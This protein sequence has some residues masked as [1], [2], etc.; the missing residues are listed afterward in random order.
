VKTGADDV[1]LLERECPG[2]RPAIRGRDIGA[3]ECHPRRYL[4]WTHGA[5]GLPLAQLTRP[6]RERLAC[7]EAR[8]RQR[9]DYRAGPPWQLFRTALGLAPHRVVWPDL[10]RRL[11]AVVPPADIV[12]LNTVYGIAT[13]DAADAG[14]LCVLLNSRWLTA[15]A[16]LVAD[17]ARGGFRRFNARVVRELPVPA[18]GS[19]AW[20]ELTRR[21][22]ARDPADDFIADLFGL[23]V[24]ERRA[25]AAHSV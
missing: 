5:D 25:L 16:R 24:A 2:T 18:R 8:L 7:H 4:L 1:F 15:L 6:A 11:E 10:G 21:G 3:W 13:R 14:A 12:P 17:P 19:P 20:E 22:Q 9:S 23:D